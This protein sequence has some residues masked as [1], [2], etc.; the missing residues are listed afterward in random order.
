[1]GM[2]EILCLIIFAFYSIMILS[3]SYLMPKYLHTLI[4]NTLWSTNMVHIAISVVQ[5][6]AAVFGVLYFPSI[7]VVFSK[8]FCIV[9]VI[10]AW[11]FGVLYYTLAFLLYPKIVSSHFEYTFWCMFSTYPEN[12]EIVQRYWLVYN[13]PFPVFSLVLSIPTFIKVIIKKAMTNESSDNNTA[14]RTLSK[15]KS[16]IR[17]MLLCF[18]A[19]TS[20]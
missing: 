3:Q 17:Y 16:L 5:R 18:C 9:F 11:I 7:R 19:T 1:M 13:F 2:S 12:T 14:S 6:F 20:C 4:T 8:N 15:E 10:F